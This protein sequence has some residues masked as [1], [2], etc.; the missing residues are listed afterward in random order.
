MCK[1]CFQ[2]VT[3]VNHLLISIFIA[4][5]I[6]FVNIYI[7]T[8]LLTNILLISICSSFVCSLLFL[9]HL[10]SFFPSI[11]FLICI[12]MSY[13]LCKL[14]SNYEEQCGDSLKNWEQNCHMT[15]SSH[16]WAYS[17]R[18][19]ELKETHVHQCSLQ[20]CLQ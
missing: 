15:Q 17:L 6:C 1:V 5:C 12:H 20:Q 4:F 9:V 7:E 2:R 16:C 13:F 18:K 10:S 11:H 19:P 8:P 14:V 3:F